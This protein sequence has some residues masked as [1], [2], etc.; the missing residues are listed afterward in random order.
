VIAGSFTGRSV[1]VATDVGILIEVDLSAALVCHVQ[2]DKHS[3]KFLA[4]FLLFVLGFFVFFASNGISIRG[5]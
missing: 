4:F 3:D 2:V 5:A 1:L